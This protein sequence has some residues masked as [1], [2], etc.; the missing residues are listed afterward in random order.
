MEPTIEEIESWTSDADRAYWEMEEF[1]AE[2][3]AQDKIWRAEVRE[4]SIAA[5]LAA[6]APDRATAERW[7]EMV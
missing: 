4:A 6:G 7:M 3:E 5:A 2:M 1:L